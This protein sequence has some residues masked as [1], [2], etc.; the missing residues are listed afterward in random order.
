MEVQ[1]YDSFSLVKRKEASKTQ[2]P[3]NVIS[4]KATK[5][6]K[7]KWKNVICFVF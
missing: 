1:I 3:K 4:Q 7:E 2:T 6:L 5:E